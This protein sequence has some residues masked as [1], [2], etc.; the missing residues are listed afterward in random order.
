M[1]GGW[2]YIMTNGAHGTLYIG[3]TAKLPA[4]VLAH[5]EGRGSEFCKEHNLTRLVHCEWYDSMNEAIT[6]EK[7]MK[8]WKRQ[9]K[10]KLIRR[11]NPDWN[12][13]FETINA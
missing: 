10:L 8:A 9:W 4:R 11:D 6:R 1:T 2:V 5:R 12:D 3:V 13:L 7:Q